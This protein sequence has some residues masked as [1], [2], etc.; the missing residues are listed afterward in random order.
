MQHSGDARQDGRK[1]PPTIDITPDGYRVSRG[2]SGNGPDFGRGA[3]PR[4][5]LFGGILSLVLVGLILIGA[6]ALGVLTFLIALPIAVGAIVAA[7]VFGL[8]LRHRLRKAVSEQN[9]QNGPPGSRGGHGQG[10][11]G[12]GGHGQGGHGQGGHGR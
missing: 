12:Q 5:G 1:E 11:H 9:R 8:V 4:R 10:G 3:A 6:F 2:G 7:I